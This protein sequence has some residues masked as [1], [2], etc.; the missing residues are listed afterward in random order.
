LYWVAVQHT[1]AR[2]NLEGLT[3]KLKEGYTS[4]TKLWLYRRKGTLSL[5]AIMYE[6]N[7]E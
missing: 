3:S 6:E 4:K 2:Q 1:P 5:I 7:I